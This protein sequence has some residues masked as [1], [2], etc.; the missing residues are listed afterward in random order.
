MEIRAFIQGDPYV[1]KK[2]RG[3][4]QG[5]KEWVAAIKTQTR[6]LERISGRCELEVEFIL[7]PGSSPTDH[8]YGPDLDNL[9]KNLLDGIDDTILADA[10]S[11]DGAIVR[12]IASKRTKRGEEPTG[13]KI[14]VRPAPESLRP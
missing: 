8:P 7:W 14:V 12:V 3:R 2:T 1:K 11:G 10:P 9:L 13:A 5:P 4:T 6:D